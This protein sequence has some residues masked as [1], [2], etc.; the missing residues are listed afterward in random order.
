M[1]NKMRITIAD[2]LIGVKYK[3]LYLLKNR[4]IRYVMGKDNATGRF[5]LYYSK[6]RMVGLI[7]FDKINEIKDFDNSGAITIVNDVMQLSNSVD[8]SLLHYK[9]FDK[10]LLRCHILA[11]HVCKEN[12]AFFKK[13]LKTLSN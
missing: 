6:E 4:K 8:Y 12:K 5:L 3:I 13:F 1:Y 10:E 7:P 2:F 11:N 9:W